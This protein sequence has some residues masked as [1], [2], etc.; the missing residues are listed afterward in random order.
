MGSQ[1]SPKCIPELEDFIQLWISSGCINFRAGQ[2]EMAA[3]L[4]CGGGEIESGRRGGVG[5]KGVGRG[6]GESG[7][8]HSR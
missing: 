4:E 5:E 6:S 3:T 8:L 7:Q 2:D 1:K